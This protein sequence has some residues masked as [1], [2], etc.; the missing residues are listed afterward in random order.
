VLGCRPAGREAGPPEASL[1]PYSAEEAVLFNDSVA[2]QVIR[3][4]AW[5]PDAKLADRVARADSVVVARIVTITLGQASS[6]GPTLRI[7]LQPLSSPLAGAVQTGMLTFNLAADNPAYML[8]RLRARTLIGRR[9]VLF[10]R[11]YAD[12]PD[13]QL[14]FRA[15]PDSPEV[16]AAILRAKRTE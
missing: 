1:P 6:A 15:E 4:A 16:H 9:L 11:T 5:T 10:F 3:P 7:D 13:T 2:G 8:F 12:G 14:H